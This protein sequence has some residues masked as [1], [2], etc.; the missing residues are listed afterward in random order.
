MS[1][2][3][4]RQVFRA[5]ETPAR[6]AAGTATTHA[7]AR[8]CSHA[9]PQLEGR[10]RFGEGVP[11][12]RFPYAFMRAVLQVVLSAFCRVRVFN[13]HY[14]PASGGA[15]YICNHQ[16]FLDPML[17]S[18]ALRR[19]MNY[20]ARDT[21]F[22]VP[23]FAQLITEF[24]AFPVKR[25]TADLGAMKEAMRRIKAG[26]QVVLFAEGTRT[27]DGRIGPFLPGV[28]LLA[29]RVAQWTVPVVIDGAFESWPRTQ[30]FPSMGNIIVQYGPPIPQ[31]DAARHSAEEFINSVRKTIIN[32]QAE[33]RQ[34]MGRPAIK[35]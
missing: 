30:K 7:P 31:E 4:A 6:R 13:R 2:E 23:G 18:Y 19:P 14:E 11:G 34:R 24:Y 10:F 5:G 8:L 33:V 9:N 32:M 12:P 25:G 21:L 35:Y 15:V 1:G 16:S 17:M 26:G 3:L 27:L 28:A 20:M 22:R 29:Q